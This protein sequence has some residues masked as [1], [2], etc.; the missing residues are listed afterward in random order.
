MTYQTLSKIFAG[1]FLALIVLY[2]AL[3][4]EQA[5][6]PDSQ[7]QQILRIAKEVRKQIVTLPQYGVFDNINFG[8]KNQTVILTGKA[9]RPTLNLELRTL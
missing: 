4:Q 7:A 2:P 8:I 1:V 5:P 6:N 9:S 3:A